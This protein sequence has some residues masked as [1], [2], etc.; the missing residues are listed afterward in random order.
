MSIFKGLGIALILLTSNISIAALDASTQKGLADEV[1]SSQRNLL[2]DKKLYSSDKES[3]LLAEKNQALKEEN[4]GLLVEK[5]SENSNLEFSTTM[6]IFDYKS[7]SQY[8]EVSKDGDNESSEIKNYVF[9][10]KLREEFS[11]KDFNKLLDSGDKID[12]S[13]LAGN[14]LSDV[15][16]QIPEPETYMMLLVG[17]MLLA[18]GHRKNKQNNFN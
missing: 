3:R 5:D 2:S 7:P 15:I 12:V 17:L 14:N 9:S 11:F 10:D 16:P 4:K 1:K 6:C 8:R 13:N 18:L